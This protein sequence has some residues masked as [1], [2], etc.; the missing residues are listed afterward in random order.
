[1]H[2]CLGPKRRCERACQRARQRNRAALE[3]RL[4]RSLLRLRA[5]HHGIGIGPVG[6]GEV[7]G[8][9]SYLKAPKPAATSAYLTASEIFPLETRA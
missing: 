7:R 9:G 5:R 8:A 3:R 4:R 2:R 6:I 1:M